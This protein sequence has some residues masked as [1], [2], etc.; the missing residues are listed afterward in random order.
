MKGVVAVENDFVNG[1]FRAFTD[2]VEGQKVVGFLGFLE[3]EFRS[4]SQVAFGGIEFFNFVRGCYQLLFGDRFAREEGCGFFKFDDLDFLF[5][6]KVTMSRIGCSTT[7][8]VRA[9]R[10]VPDLAV[11]MEMSLKWPRFQRYCMVPESSGPGMRTV[12]PSLI[13]RLAFSSSSS[14]V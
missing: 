13:G 3:F 6:L 10:F 12:L 11:S 8:K 7:L 14:M 5:P 9:V 1:Y 2:G 4:G